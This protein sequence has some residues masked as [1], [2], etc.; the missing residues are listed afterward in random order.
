MLKEL[1]G[2]RRESSQKKQKGSKIAFGEEYER[3]GTVKNMRFEFFSY[4]AGRTVCIL[5][6]TENLFYRQQI[7]PDVS[8]SE[9]LIR[10]DAGP[11][12]SFTEKQMDR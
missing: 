8:E 1:E 11:C 2:M 12:V 9:N 6:D 7:P 4:T 10:T 5:Q 3:Q